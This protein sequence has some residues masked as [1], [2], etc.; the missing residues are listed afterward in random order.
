MIPTRFA[1]KL[2]HVIALLGSGLFH[3]YAT[4]RLHRYEIV[5]VYAKSV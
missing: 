2:Y 5:D 4:R 1:P 3:L